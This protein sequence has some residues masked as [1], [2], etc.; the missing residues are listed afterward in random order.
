MPNS[1]LRGISFKEGVLYGYENRSSVYDE[2]FLSSLNID[3]C[4]VKNFTGIKEL[5][6]IL[7]SIRISLLQ[8]WIAHEHF[9]NTCS[10]H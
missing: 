5:F 7:F 6:I 1:I 4:W 2:K 9:P 10:N 3:I 8:I